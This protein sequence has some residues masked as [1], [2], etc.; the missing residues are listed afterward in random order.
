GDG[1]DLV[2]HQAPPIDDAEI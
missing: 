1:V 2:P